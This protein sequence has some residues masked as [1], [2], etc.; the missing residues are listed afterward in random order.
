MWTHI[1]IVYN[2]EP[3]IHEASGLL[4]QDKAAEAAAAYMSATIKTEPPVCQRITAGKNRPTDEI[5][6]YSA[7]FA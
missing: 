6:R 4:P 2:G 1:L 7:A 3:Y 5:W